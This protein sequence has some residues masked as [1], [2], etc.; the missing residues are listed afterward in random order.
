MIEV[1]QDECEFVVGQRV[2]STFDGRRGVVASIFRGQERYARWIVKVDW[3]P[4]FLEDNVS[5]RIVYS[6]DA[7]C[8]IL[9][10]EGETP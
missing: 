3:E 5:T 4:P 10:S 7:K 9:E 1:L 6:V 8:E 2:R